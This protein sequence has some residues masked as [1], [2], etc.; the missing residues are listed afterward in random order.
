MVV[1]EIFFDFIE[2][3]FVD[4]MILNY[5]WGEIWKGGFCVFIFGLNCYFGGIM[6]KL[7]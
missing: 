3:M 2:I 5:G 6:K 1:F 7:Y 4:G